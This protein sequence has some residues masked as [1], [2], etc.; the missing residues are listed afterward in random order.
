MRP[1]ATFA[2]WYSG[3]VLATCLAWTAVGVYALDEY[4]RAWGPGRMFL[5]V[6][7]IALLVSLVALFSSGV[8]AR[9]GRMSLRTPHWVPVTLGVLFVVLNFVLGKIMEVVGIP[10]A[11]T[12][13]ILY[14]VLVPAA[15]AY[16]AATRFREKRL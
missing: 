1:F 5:I 13:M 10:P 12:A 3:A 16:A 2:L 8:G 7:C 15:M 4:E 14:V 6:A 11:R 9:L